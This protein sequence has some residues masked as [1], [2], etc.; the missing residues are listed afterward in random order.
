MTQYQ[1]TV[2]AEHVQHLFT[3]D[4]AVA[5]FVEGIVQQILEAQVS[6]HLHAQPYERTA[7]RPTRWA[8][9]CSPPAPACAR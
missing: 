4:G 9:C 7:A 6:E 2:D 5:R 1:L 8:G 3:Q